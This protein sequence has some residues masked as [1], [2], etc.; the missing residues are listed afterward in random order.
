MEFNQIAYCC[1]VPA[2]LFLFFFL[3]K[4][5]RGLVVNL[6]AVSNL[7][8]IGYSVFLIRQFM[9]FYHLAKQLGVT[10]TQI[11]TTPV[12][13]ATIRLLLVIILPFFSLIGPLRKN[14][15]FSLLLLVLV[16]WN[17][18]LH[19]WNTYDLFVKIPAY[20]SAFCAAYALLW[21]FKKLAYQPR[22]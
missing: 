3:E 6:L 15:L 12:D 17:N 7:L 5:S 4:E 14:R 11:Q 20:L 16:Y 13:T 21:L 19:S 10:Q 9:A 18:P 1:S 2:L 22:N 8:L